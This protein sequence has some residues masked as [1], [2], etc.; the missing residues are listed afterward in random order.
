[1][2]QIGR[3]NT[4]KI[5]H[6]DEKGAWLQAGRHQILLPKAEVPT[7][8]AAGK[9]LDVFLCRD[10]EGDVVATLKRPL[11]QEGE[12]A[13]L[14]VRQVTSFG[15]FLDW[16][17]EKDLL[18]P[19][20]EQPERMQV[21]RKYL[22]KICLDSLG[23]LVGTARIDKCLEAEQIDLREGEEVELIL[24]Q[25]TDLGAKVIVND[26]Y[27]GLLYKDEIR[28]GLKRGDRLKGVVK[29]LR[30]DNKIDVT[31]RKGGKEETEGA[32]AVILAALEKSGSLPLHDHSPPE[33][34]RQ[35]LGMS[36]KTFKKAVGGLYKAGRLELS[37]EGIRLKRP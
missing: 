19:F 21:G 28:S 37:G 8:A 4:L 33:Q 29:H 11:A 26:L 10:K 34:V 7:G 27:Q 3:I 35:V 18:V 1:M 2:Y 25:F 23:R 13:L 31:L 20:G 12:F 17:M 30:E 16:G 9:R 22:V 36:K 24:W 15:A 6:L 14:K 5:N 32:M